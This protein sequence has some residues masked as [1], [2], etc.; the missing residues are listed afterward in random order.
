M[1]GYAIVDQ[2]GNSYACQERSYVFDRFWRLVVQPWMTPEVLDDREMFRRPAALGVSTHMLEPAASLPPA[3]NRHSDAL[4]QR[5]L[6]CIF[7][8]FHD[9]RRILARDDR[10][11]QDH[12][13]NAVGVHRGEQEPGARACVGAP[14]YSFLYPMSVEFEIYIIC[15]FNMTKGSTAGGRKPMSGKVN[16]ENPIVRLEGVDLA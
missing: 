1:V 12:A 5:F 6:P 15:E 14:E 10:P 2:N 9:H 16:Q 13:L 4:I 8:R 11:L 7:D 3:C